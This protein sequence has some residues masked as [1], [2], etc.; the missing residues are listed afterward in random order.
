[1]ATGSVPYSYT[2]DYTSD[3]STGQ[4]GNMHCT[5][6][7]GVCNTALQFSSS[8]NRI[9]T[10]GYGYDAAGNL[11][12]VPGPLAHTYQYDAEG[13]LSSVDNGTTA[14]YT[15]NALGWAVEEKAGGTAH[16]ARIQRLGPVDGLHGQQFGEGG[17]HVA[18]GAAFRDL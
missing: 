10:S 15:Y 1:M 2:F 6:N 18:A 5:A 13:R 3:G 17:L 11:T 12:S 16:G 9:T 14:S 8:T 7:G 4:Y